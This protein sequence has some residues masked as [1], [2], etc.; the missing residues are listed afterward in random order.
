MNFNLY[1]DSATDRIGTHRLRQG[2]AA[3]ALPE[4]PL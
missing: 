4:F 2:T 1:V 3:P